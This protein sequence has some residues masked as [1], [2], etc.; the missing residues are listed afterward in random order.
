MAGLALTILLALLWLAFVGLGYWHGGWRQV[1]L[2]AGMLLSYA[3]ASEW[4]VP[5]GHDLATRFHWSLPRATTAV[6]LLYLLGG[7]LVV[8]SPRQLRIGATLS[9][10]HGWSGNAARRSACSTAG[11][12]SRSSCGRSDR[13]RMSRVA[14]TALHTSALSRF[15]IESIGYR[16]ARRARARPRRGRRWAHARATAAR[17]R[18][19]DTR[20][21]AS[22]G[23]VAS[24]PPPQQ[25][26]PQ[27][28]NVAPPAPL[29]SPPRA[30][31]PAPVYAAEP[32]IDWPDRRRRARGS[33]RA[34]RHKELRRPLHTR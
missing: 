34:R 6:G 12:C 23:H 30:P 16:L 9:V 5:N 11:C 28:V 25:T 2:L 29:R 26:E 20:T 7:T 33:S 4:A 14:V 31:T 24:P 1:V 19:P 10:H 15:L 21:G 18:E 13:T 32:I 22:T 8:G 27:P 3:V 17:T